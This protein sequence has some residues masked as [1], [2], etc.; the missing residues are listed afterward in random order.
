MVVVSGAAGVEVGKHLFLAHPSGGL[1]NRRTI[2]W[3]LETIHTLV[4]HRLWQSFKGIDDLWL[5][6]GF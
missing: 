2:L 5:L 4:H 1:L 3:M 6:P